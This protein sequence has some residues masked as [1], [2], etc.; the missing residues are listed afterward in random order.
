M[1]ML[2]KKEQVSLAWHLSPKTCKKLKS[3][4]LEVVSMGLE[5]TVL[6]T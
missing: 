6:Y 3:Q 2:K 5:V 1:H 4:E